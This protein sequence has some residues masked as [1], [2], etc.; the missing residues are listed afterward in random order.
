MQQDAFVNCCKLRITADSSV[1][2]PYHPKL[3]LIHRQDNLRGGDALLCF[4]PTV[5]P[6]KNWLYRYSYRIY[7][8][9]SEESTR[10]SK[11]S[12]SIQLIREL[13]C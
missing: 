6:A 9:D 4:I 12:S 5:V 2:Q 10:R 1:I 11:S 3:W 13:F 7:A 8:R